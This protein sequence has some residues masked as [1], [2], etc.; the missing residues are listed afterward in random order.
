MLEIKHNNNILNQ[1]RRIIYYGHN[2]MIELNKEIVEEFCDLCDRSHEAWITH[3]TLFDDNPKVEDLIK[4]L[5]FFS[6]LSIITQE[7]SLQQFIKLHDPEK[8][9]GYNNLSFKFIIKYG[10]WSKETL[11]ML[12]DLFDKMEETMGRSIKDARNNVL[13][14]NDLNTIINKLTHGKFP[15]GADIEYINLMHEF[16]NIVHDQYIGGVY[17]FR[18]LAK[19]EAENLLERVQIKK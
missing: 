10:N 4:D 5:P 11:K 13:S 18:D 9:K 8:Q 1:D 17:I 12:N 6:R 16:I 2:I 15:L 3:K 7:Y 14:H 19:R